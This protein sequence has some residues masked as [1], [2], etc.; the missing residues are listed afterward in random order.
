MFSCLWPQKHG[1]LLVSTKLEDCWD[2]TVYHVHTL[3]MYVHTLE[4]PKVENRQFFDVK[5]EKNSFN[6]N[7]HA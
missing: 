5:E 1:T 4:L 7:Q 3:E 2:A 6:Y